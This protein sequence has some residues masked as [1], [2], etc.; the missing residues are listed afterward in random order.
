MLDVCGTIVLKLAAD[1]VS[2]SNEII[3]MILHFS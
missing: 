1:A 2:H 3:I